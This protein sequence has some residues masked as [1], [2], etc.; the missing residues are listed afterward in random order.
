MF[1]HIARDKVR[2]RANAGDAHLRS[3]QLRGLFEEGD[4]PNLER[5]QINR[6]TQQHDIGSGQIRR[7]HVRRAGNAIC[8]SPETSAAVESVPPE[9]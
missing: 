5:Q 2:R 7:D 4:R 3:F 9:R 8:T 6:R 1:E